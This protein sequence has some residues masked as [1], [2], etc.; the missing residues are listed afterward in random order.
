MTKV[1]LYYD[2]KDFI[3]N[4]NFDIAQLQSK[5]CHTL[6]YVY[7]TDDLIQ[8]L[9]KETDFFE[10]PASTRYHSNFQGGLAYHSLCVLYNLLRL[11]INPGD[12]ENTVSVRDDLSSFTKGNDSLS[13][14]S[15]IKIVMLLSSTSTSTGTSDRLPPSSMRISLNTT[16]S[17]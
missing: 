1:K 7:D 2:L 3:F 10:A 12:D 9:I 5:I 16:S 8:Y 6:Q 17:E 4:Q 13:I 14:S 15:R 11:N